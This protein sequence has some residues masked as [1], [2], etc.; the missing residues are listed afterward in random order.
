MEPVLITGGTGHLGRD[1]SK[2]LLSQGR[3]IR[4]L[5][6][7]AGRNPIIQWALGD[8]ATGKGLAD[9]VRGVNIVIHAA[10]LS[11]IAKRGGIRPIDFFTT[12]TSVDVDGTRRLLD[13]CKRAGVGHFLHVSIVGLDETSLPYARAKLAGENLVRQSQV[14]YSIIRATPSIIS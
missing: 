9:A 6:R 7:T 3:P 8:L 11:P 10:T 5:A 12:P 13:E 1:I 14:P 2:C 4:I